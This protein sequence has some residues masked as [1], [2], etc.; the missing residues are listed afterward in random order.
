MPHTQPASAAPEAAAPQA[1]IHY[2]RPPMVANAYGFGPGMRE[3][4]SS[5][6]LP[7]TGSNIRTQACVHR[8]AACDTAMLR[9][10]IEFGAAVFGVSA[11]PAELR[12]LA[13]RLIDAAHDIESH[14]AR[15]LLQQHMGASTPAGQVVSA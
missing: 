14:P 11:T 15:T 9:V 1:F 8:F 10:D 4:G 12:E 13:A 6:Y 5:E 3:M 7:L 2:P